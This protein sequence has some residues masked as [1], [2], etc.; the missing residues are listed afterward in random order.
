[1]EEL[2][3]AIILEEEINYLLVYCMSKSATGIFSKR[4]D[5]GYYC[6]LIGRYVMDN[7]TKFREFF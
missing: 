1:M 7:E 4:K 6:S 3:A 5:R 2:I